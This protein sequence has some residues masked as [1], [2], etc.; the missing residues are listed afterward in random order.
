MIDSLPRL[1]KIEN[2][3][4]NCDLKLG[5][6]NTTSNQVKGLP[7]TMFDIC[8]L[9]PFSDE[10]LFY[11]EMLIGAGRNLMFQLINVYTING[12]PRGFR[13]FGIKISKSQ[14]WDDTIDGGI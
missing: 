2:T 11:A 8:G 7:P 4:V 14:H 9:D 13:R 12:A 6:D 1:L 10:A 5:P 3:D